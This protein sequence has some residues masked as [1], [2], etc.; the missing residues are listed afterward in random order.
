MSSDTGPSSTL[1][2]LSVYAQVSLAMVAG[3][4]LVWAFLG[5]LD[6][7]IVMV[8]DP[9]LQAR[10]Q[11]AAD[12]TQGNDQWVV[13]VLKLVAP[14]MHWGTLALV[15]SLVTFPLLGWL[16]GRYAE[17]PSWAG[18]LPLVDLVSGL[19]PIRLGGNDLIAP[20]PLDQ[21][22]GLLLLQILGIHL[23]AHLAHARRLARA[24][25]SATPPA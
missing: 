12:S 19:N 1:R 14:R 8:A 7:Q 24:S 5:G 13:E 16:L 10:V 20:L 4:Y 15:A 11:A 17:D 23:T 9:A 22:V 18:I 3:V 2:N 25:A 21:Q 6:A